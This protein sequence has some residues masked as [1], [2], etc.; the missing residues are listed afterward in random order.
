[1]NQGGASGQATRDFGPDDFPALGGQQGQQGTPQSQE[2]GSTGS[3][4]QH[5]PGLNGFQQS[6]QA[7]RQTMLANALGAQ[8]RGLH[9]AFDQ[10][11]RVSQ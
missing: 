11:K 1:M 3:G 5:P 2:S 6:E 7:H 9:T 8:P 10:E 4:Q